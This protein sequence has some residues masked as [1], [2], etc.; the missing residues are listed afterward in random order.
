[1]ED[2][3]E[4]FV[5]VV[6]VVVV[7]IVFFDGFRSCESTDGLGVTRRCLWIE[8]GHVYAYLVGLGGGFVVPV[9]S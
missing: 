8:P 4:S 6:A 7:A 3:S 9:V 5:V 1:M 2:G